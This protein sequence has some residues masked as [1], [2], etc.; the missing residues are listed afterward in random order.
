MRKSSIFDGDASVENTIDVGPIPSNE[1][2][3]NQ[4]E[5]RTGTVCN[6]KYVNLRRSPIANGP[7]IDVLENGDEGLIMEKVPGFYRIKVV[8]N[9]KDGYIAEHYFRED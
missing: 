6:S 8:K 2:S 9:G 7:V 5:N 3:Q 4:L 1:G